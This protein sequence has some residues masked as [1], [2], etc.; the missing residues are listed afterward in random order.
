MS[1]IDKIPKNIIKKQHQAEYI[2]LP[3]NNAGI[4]FGGGFILDDRADYEI[5]LIQ[6][7]NQGLCGSME[8]VPRNRHSGLIVYAVNN[9]CFCVFRRENALSGIQESTLMWYELH[10]NDIS[11]YLGKDLK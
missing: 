9:L 2:S 7:G 10:H 1:N 4:A 3:F 11:Y 8:Y 5:P 6:S